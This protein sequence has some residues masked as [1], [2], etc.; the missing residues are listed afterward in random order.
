MDGLEGAEINYLISLFGIAR[1]AEGLDISNIRSATPGNWNDMIGCQ[2]S[3]LLT[4]QAYLAV[5]LT[6]LLPLFG[7]IL[8]TGFSFSSSVSMPGSVANV[9]VSPL[10]KCLFALDLFGIRLDVFYFL[11]IDSVSV[12]CNV[13]VSKGFYLVWILES[14]ITP[15]SQGLVTI[16]LIGLFTSGLD[17]LFVSLVGLLAPFLFLIILLLGS[18]CEALPFSGAFAHLAMR[19]VPIGSRRLAVKLIYRL[20]F[21]ASGTGFNGWHFGS[22]IETPRRLGG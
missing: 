3:F 6:E 10:I 1:L 5:T 19:C 9:W 8:T 21:F 18:L 14:V 16:L 20:F 12:L 4:A 13:L 11:L 22:K 2:L 15:I 17:V 7:R